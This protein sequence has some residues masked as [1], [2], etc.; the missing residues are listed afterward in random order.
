MNQIEKVRG[1]YVL[2]LGGE[3]FRSKS[4]GELMDTVL[5]YADRAIRNNENRKYLLTKDGTVL[6]VHWFTQQW[7]YDIMHPASRYP[8][9][10]IIPKVNFQEAVEKAISH[11]EQSYGGLVEVPEP[12]HV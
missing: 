7:G 5:Q 6:C 10:C 4:K 3:I 2:H 9:S 12:S 11:A 8:S 1:G